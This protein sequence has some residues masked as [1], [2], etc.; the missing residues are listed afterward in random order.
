MAEVENARSGLRVTIEE[1]KY[2][3]EDLLTEEEIIKALDA[4]TARDP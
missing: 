4:E 3:K 2:E 1:A